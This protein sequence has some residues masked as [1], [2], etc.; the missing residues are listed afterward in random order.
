MVLGY[1][2]CRKVL[3]IPAIRSVVPVDNSIYQIVEGMVPLP[4]DHEHEAAELG[5]SPRMTRVTFD[6]DPPAEPSALAVP[7]LAGPTVNTADSPVDAPGRGS[8]TYD[9]PVSLSR[10]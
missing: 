8:Q 3:Y 4:V 2:L 10:S 1:L 7:F 6:W 9:P 5:L